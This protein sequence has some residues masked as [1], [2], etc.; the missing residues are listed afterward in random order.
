MDRTGNDRAN[1][2]CGEIW[3][4]A[5]HRRFGWRWNRFLGMVRRSKTKAAGPRSKAVRWTLGVHRTPKAVPI[6]CLVLGSQ[7]FEKLLM[8]GNR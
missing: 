5:G 4:A 6:G 7:R 8:N 3:S 1:A 2:E